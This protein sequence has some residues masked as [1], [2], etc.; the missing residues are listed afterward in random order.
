VKEVKKA[1]EVE[2]AVIAETPEETAAFLARAKGQV[3]PA[4][5]VSLFN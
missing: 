1:K 3:Q 2:A 4:K 5:T